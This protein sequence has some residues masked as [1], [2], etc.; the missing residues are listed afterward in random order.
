[1]RT[2]STVQVVAWMRV[3]TAISLGS[4]LHVAPTESLSVVREKLI[5]DATIT[6]VVVRKNFIRRFHHRR[7]TRQSR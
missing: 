5:A 7:G 2:H 4:T 6:E 3:L 1:M